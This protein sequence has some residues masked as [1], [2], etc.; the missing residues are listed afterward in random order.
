MSGD[1]DS[2]KDSQSTKFEWRPRIFVKLSFREFIL[3]V[4]RFYCEFV[5]RLK[6]CGFH[7]KYSLLAGDTNQ[8]SI[9]SPC[10]IHKWV[11]STDWSTLT[12]SYQAG[13]NLENSSFL[14]LSS[15]EKLEQ[16]RATFKIPV[17]NL[18]VNW[19]E[20]IYSVT[21]LF[22]NVVKTEGIYIKSG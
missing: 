1:F 15:W 16:P 9:S 19:G 14:S 6:N 13:P 22:K 18:C 4:E 7:T 11:N 5:G 2:R 21:T 12:I 8:A 20:I 3:P 10:I 17:F